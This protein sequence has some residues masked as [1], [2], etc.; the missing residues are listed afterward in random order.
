MALTPRAC[1]SFVLLFVLFP[2][3]S[4]SDGGQGEQL[5]VDVINLGGDG[6]TQGCVQPSFSSE[7]PDLYALAPPRFLTDA[8]NGQ[9]VVDPGD[10]IDAEITVNAATKQVFIE[11]R[12]AWDPPFVIYSTELTTPGDERIPLV[13][14]PQSE[15]QGRFY[16]K[17]TLCGS[18]CDEREVVF[19]LN[20]DINS[21]YE[22]TLIENGEIIQVDRTC[23]D[24]T[25]DAGIGSGTVVIQ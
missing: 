6:G 21:P 18:D 10:P 12:D 3:S 11:L 19:D 25:A 23:I 24:L 17:I 14:Q 16:M 8:P 20:P 15:T 13:L 1:F 7:Q 5:P 4:C 9:S 22:R 2:L